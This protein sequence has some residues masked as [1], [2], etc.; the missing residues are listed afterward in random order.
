VAW[1]A[2]P[3]TDQAAVLEALDLHDAVPATLRMGFSAWNRN[4][5]WRRFQLTGAALRLSWPDWDNDLDEFRSREVFVTPALDGWTLV[6]G[7]AFRL[8]EV[9]HTVDDDEVHRR[10]RALSRRFGAAHWY[11]QYSGE[12]MEVT[13]WFNLWDAPTARW[14]VAVAGSVQRYCEVVNGVR[15]GSRLR[16]ATDDA[17]ALEQL[18]SWLRD[19][20]HGRG[21]RPPEPKLQGDPEVVQRHWEF[22]VK[23]AAWRLSVCP[24]TLGPHT[25]VQGSGVLA[26]PAAIAGQTRFDAYPF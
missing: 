12:H 16:D 18:R 19:N 1:F 20:D 11:C 23:G 8:A 26:V 7:D 6:M 2:L 13:D 17:A 15:T 24:E 4:Q 25:R 3:T 9:N 5:S 21:H 22:G 14:C 10:C